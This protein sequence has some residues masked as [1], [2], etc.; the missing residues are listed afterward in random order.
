MTEGIIVAADTVHHI[1]PLKDDWNKRIDID[2]MISLSGDTHSM[3]EQEY[4]KDK[5]GKFPAGTINDLVY[6]KLK[7]YAKI[8]SSS[9][10]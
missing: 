2:N 4:K 1:I 5:D 10:K 8:D 7:S 3:I 9:E 6:K